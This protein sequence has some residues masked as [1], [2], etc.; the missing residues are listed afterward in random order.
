MHGEVVRASAG[1]VAAEMLDKHPAASPLDA[2]LGAASADDLLRAAAAGTA[3]A[4][5]RAADLTRMVEELFA[6]LPRF[7]RYVQRLSR[8]SISSDSSTCRRSCA[9]DMLRC[10]GLLF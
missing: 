8:L 4:G 9:A 7:T 2:E 6:D 5:L 10:Y 1:S 3:G